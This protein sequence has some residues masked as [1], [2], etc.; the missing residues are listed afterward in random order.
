MEITS[1]I[2]STRILIFVLYFIFLITAILLSLVG[3]VE[4]SYG[5]LHKAPTKEER[6]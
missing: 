1:A 5:G 6:R 4:E 2:K 3:Y